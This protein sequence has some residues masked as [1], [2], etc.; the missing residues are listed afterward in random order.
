MGVTVELKTEIQVT[1]EKLLGRSLNREPGY[2][3][4]DLIDLLMQVR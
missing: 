1:L 3:T 2:R 4:H